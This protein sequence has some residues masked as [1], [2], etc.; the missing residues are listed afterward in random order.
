MQV[1]ESRAI[2][3]TPS[4]PSSSSSSDSPSNCFTSQ[5][6]WELLNSSVKKLGMERVS[7]V[8]SFLCCW[9]GWISAE[10]ED[11]EEDEEEDEVEEEL[12]VAIGDVESESDLLESEPERELLEDLD[13]CWTVIEQREAFNK[14]PSGNL[15]EKREWIRAKKNKRRKEG[16][17]R[18]YLCLFLALFKKHCAKA[19]VE[20]S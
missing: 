7:C 1:P 19:G 12:E 4:S 11:A 10:E 20:G 15:K 18:F 16:S 9:T 14:N 3:P 13:A 17:S 8:G 5:V 6:C 2:A